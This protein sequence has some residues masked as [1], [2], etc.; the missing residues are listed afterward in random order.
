MGFSIVERRLCGIGSANL[1]MLF[2]SDDAQHRGIG[3]R[4]FE[5]ACAGAKT[6]GARYLYI[7]AT[8]KEN[9]ISFCQKYEIVQ[10]A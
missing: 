6:L 9:T 1:A 2:V 8:P 3:T 4:L 10:Y 5:A 7:S